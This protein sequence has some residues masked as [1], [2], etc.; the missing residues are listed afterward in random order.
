MT[1]KFEKVARTVEAVSQA[2]QQFI[3]QAQ[4]LKRPG[5]DWSY[6]QERYALRAVLEGSVR[7]DEALEEQR[8]LATQTLQSTV[9]I[10]NK[11]QSQ[12]ENLQQKVQAMRAGSPWFFFVFVPHPAHAAPAHWEVPAR[13]CQR[14]AEPQPGQGPSKFGCGFCGGFEFGKPGCLPQLGHVTS[15]RV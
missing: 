6:E 13:A 2:D 10:I 1:T 7:R 15:V 11:L 14:R 4:E 5:S 8:M 9:E 12:M 3:T